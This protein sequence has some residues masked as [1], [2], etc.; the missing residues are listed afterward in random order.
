MAIIR[1]K[2]LA[3]L[4]RLIG[5]SGTP[6]P[7]ILDDDSVSLTMPLVPHLA[8]RGQAFGT[9]EG[10]WVGVLRNIH[11][12][13]DSEHVGINPYEP[14][15][16]AAIPPF[17][18]VLPLDFDLWVLG[19]A[20]RRFSGVG[21]M[22]MCICSINR[23]PGHQAWGVDDLGAQVSDTR[24]LTVARFD[25]IDTTTGLGDDPM[26]TEQGLVYQPVNMR[27]PRGAILEMDT[28]S[29]GT[30]HLDT[31]W[32]LGVFPAGLGQDVVT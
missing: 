17:P 7:T 23:V 25:A 26:M 20:G 13:A 28:V 8:R 22:T 18:A 3:P 10:W 5:R 32:V 27:I 31:N 11:T 1:T 24:I 2:I 4:Q 9:G 16:T 29:G 21:G 6:K 19:I 15:P 12:A 14:G 30:C